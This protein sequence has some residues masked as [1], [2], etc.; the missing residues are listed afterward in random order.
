M[1]AA[2]KLVRT[3]YIPC[4]NKVGYFFLN[5]CLQTVSLQFEYNFPSKIVSI[6]SKLYISLS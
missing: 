6:P 5:T 1:E 2:H 4:Q 3:R